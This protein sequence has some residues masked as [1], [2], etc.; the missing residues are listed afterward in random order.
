MMSRQR[1]EVLAILQNSSGAGNNCFPNSLM[2]IMEK[3]AM[4]RMLMLDEGSHASPADWRRVIMAD[5]SYADHFQLMFDEIHSETIPV[6]YLDVSGELL[7]CITDNYDID[8]AFACYKTVFT[9]TPVMP[10]EIEVS[11]ALRMVSESYFGVGPERRDVIMVESRTGDVTPANIKFSLRKYVESAN[12]IAPDL[13]AFIVHVNNN[14]YKYLRHD[15][16]ER[17]RAW[18]TYDEVARITHLELRGVEDARRPHGPLARLAMP[19]VSSPRAIQS[20]ASFAARLQENEIKR[21]GLG[22]NITPQELQQQFF[23]H[24]RATPGSISKGDHRP[25]GV[26]FGLLPLNLN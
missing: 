18:F 21:F 23:D 1:P 12:N 13:V 4:Q 22:A 9:T 5:A 20:N 25:R 7:R 3:P 15:T 16:D 8:I 26:P 14:H 24:K 19:R 11:R 10:S 6:R 17:D 2:G